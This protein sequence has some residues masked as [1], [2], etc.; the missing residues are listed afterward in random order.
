MRIAP[1]EERA[2]DPGLLAVA[3]DGLGHGQDVGLIEGGVEG[4]APVAGGTEGDALGGERW[5]GLHVVVGRVQSV[6]IH[7]LGR[8]RQAAVGGIRR[9]GGPS[10]AGPRASYLSKVS[11]YSMARD[12]AAPGRKG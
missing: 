9:H 4:G 5:V 2:T 6:Q 8:V 1:E 7:E 3:A 11:S 10:I 12:T